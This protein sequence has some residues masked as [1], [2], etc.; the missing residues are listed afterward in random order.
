MIWRLYLDKY[1]DRLQGRDLTLPDD[2]NWTGAEISV[3][4]DN[5]WRLN[6]S[7]VE[8]S[9]YIVPASMSMGVERIA[10]LREEADGRYISASYPGPYRAGRVAV[11]ANKAD[12]KVRAIS[13]DDRERTN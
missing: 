10:K 11:A 2:N 1:R 3:C 12:G 13:F 4:V 8:A 7:L 5:A 9:S 6:C